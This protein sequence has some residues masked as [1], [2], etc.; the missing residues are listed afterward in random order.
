LGAET[1]GFRPRGRAELVLLLWPPLL[2]EVDLV[3][4]LLLEDDLLL[5]PI[6]V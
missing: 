1:Y 2:L 3:V 5:V 4:L 6:V